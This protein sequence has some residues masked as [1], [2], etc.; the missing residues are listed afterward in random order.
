MTSYEPHNTRDTPQSSAYSY[1]ACVVIVLKYPWVIMNSPNERRSCASP[2]DRGLGFRAWSRQASRQSVPAQSVAGLANCSYGWLWVS[3]VRVTR[4]T[5]GGKG[6]SC[7]NTRSHPRHRLQPPTNLGGYAWVNGTCS[8][9]LYVVCIP[10]GWRCMYIVLPNGSL[11][12]KRQE[13]Q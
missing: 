5:A 2:T 7:P 13:M 12:K 1:I 4:A 3:D 10:A 11:P 8:N 9:A 6:V